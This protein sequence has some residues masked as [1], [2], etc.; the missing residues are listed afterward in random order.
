MGTGVV[1]NANLLIMVLALLKIGVVNRNDIGEYS[2]E[3]GPN[4]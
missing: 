1:K 2:S 4:L 3:E